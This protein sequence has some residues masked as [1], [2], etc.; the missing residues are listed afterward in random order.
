[1]ME[2]FGIPRTEIIGRTL[3]DIVEETERSFLEEAQRNSSCKKHGTARLIGISRYALARH[4]EKL[5][6]NQRKR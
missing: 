3:Y 5:G 2:F 4:M 1:M 6:M